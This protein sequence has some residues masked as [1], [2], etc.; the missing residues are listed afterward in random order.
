MSD[1]FKDTSNE[2]HIVYRVCT[3]LNLY[4]ITRVCRDFVLV[5]R[6]PHRPTEEERKRLRK[7]RDEFYEGEYL[8][9]EI[10]IREYLQKKIDEEGRGD[11]P[12]NLIK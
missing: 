3:K 6:R 8:A 5:A 2:D 12:L 7:G 9:D 1:I 4:T 11:I 10:E